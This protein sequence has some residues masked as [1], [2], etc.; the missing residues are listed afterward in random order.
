MLYSTLSCHQT[1]YADVGEA[2]DVETCCRSHRP[3]PRPWLAPPPHP[4]HHR[5]DLVWCQAHAN[6]CYLGPSATGWQL[7]RA[8][9]KVRKPMEAGE[10]ELISKWETRMGGQR[11]YC[12]SAMGM[13]EIARKKM[14][15]EEGDGSWKFKYLLL[16][17]LSIIQMPILILC[18]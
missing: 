4:K 8:G 2:G 18:W 14:K 9:G 3:P 13:G 11:P 10:E 17:Y 7:W 15:R 12:P 1:R 6:G 5:P 16:F